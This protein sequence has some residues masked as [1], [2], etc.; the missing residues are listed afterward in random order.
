MSG[1]IKY[2][3]ITGITVTVITG[4]HQ[5]FVLRD[6]FKVGNIQQQGRIQGEV[7]IRFDPPPS[8]DTKMGKQMCFTCGGLSST[9]L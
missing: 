1:L 6:G 7:F 8:H 9:S 4:P 3:L 2:M 5:V